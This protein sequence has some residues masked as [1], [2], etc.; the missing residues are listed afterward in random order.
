[1]ERKR[2]RLI[3]RLQHKYRLVVMNDQT[4][5]EKASFTLTRMNVFIALSS[6]I[7]LFMGIMVSAF[8]FTPLKEYIPGC[9]DAELRRDLA[10]VLLRTDSLESALAEKEAFLT[11]IRQVIEGNIPENN[12][13]KQPPKKD[14]TVSINVDEKA[15]QAEMELRQSVESS[16]KFSLA[17]SFVADGNPYQN[18][19]QFSRLLFMPP[20]KG[21]V[22]Q[23]YSTEDDH[24]ALDIVTKPNETVK[25]T[26]D[27]TVIFATWTPETGHVIGIQHPNNTISLY[28]HNSVLLKKAGNY[29][30]AGDAIAIV[31]NSG[32]ISTGAHLHFEIWFEGYA[33]NPENLMAFN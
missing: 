20:V 2:E 7:V 4:F 28:K 16:D 27:G 17:Q 9:N 30:K 11:N 12:P 23:R 24:Y 21:I 13:G 19:S 15:S 31:G 1:M 29:V 32:E 6:I 33:L 22:T 14:S 8:F 3:K 5:E 26:M 25:A 10:K 18:K